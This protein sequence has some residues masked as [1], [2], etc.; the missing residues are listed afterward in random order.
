M[1][2]HDPFRLQIDQARSHLLRSFDV[3]QPDPHQDCDG[4]RLPS[5]LELKSQLTSAWGSRKINR[6]SIGKAAPHLNKSSATLFLDDAIT[7][8]NFNSCSVEASGQAQALALLSEV[9]CQGW[10]STAGYLKTGCVPA[11]SLAL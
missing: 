2:L 4:K 5:L 7:D 10:L 9:A 1:V 3:K 6:L 8:F 11:D